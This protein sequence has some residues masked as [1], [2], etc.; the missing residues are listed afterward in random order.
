MEINKTSI[1]NSLSGTNDDIFIHLPYLL[2]DLWE[3]GGGTD[4]ILELLESNLS[5]FLP[6]SNIL[7]LCCGKGAVITSIINKYKCTG[8]GIDLFEPFIREAIDRAKQENIQDIL[9]FEVMDIKD[10]VATF[11]NYDLVVYGNDTDVLGDESESLRKI[12]KCCKPEGYIVYEILVKFYEEDIR[13]INDLNLRI[14]DS[15]IAE[16]DE[17]VRINEFNNKKIRQRATELIAKYPEQKELFEN[18][19][20]I[21]EKESEE[22]E[23]EF[24]LVRLLLQCK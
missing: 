6:S 20:A 8:T 3:L 1:V 22:L 15:S 7:E 24:V 13:F 10:A 12:S 9:T 4:R 14:I 5:L 17:L 23:D 2:Q 18:Y 19:V 21:Q 16:R 11:R